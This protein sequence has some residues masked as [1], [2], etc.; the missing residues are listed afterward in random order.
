MK[1]RRLSL[2]IIL[3]AGALMLAGCSGD[4]G[5]AALKG[6]ATAE[7]ALPAMVNLPDDD[8]AGE[9]RLLVTDGNLQYFA[10]QDAD[11]K[12]ACLAVVSTDSQDSW[13]A[14]CGSL[15]TSGEIVNMSSAPL[16]MS[17]VLVGDGFAPELL[18]DD[19]WKKIHDN[20]FIKSQ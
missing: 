19:G 8:N 5:L 15:N 18:E 4:P 17:A 6:P 9:S 16:A 1:N 10:A 3:A 20:V 13:H 12:R 7:D 14:G 11:H 2:T